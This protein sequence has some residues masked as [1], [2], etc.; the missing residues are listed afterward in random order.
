MPGLFHGFVFFSRP[1]DGNG[2]FP[3]PEASGR[4]ATST[5]RALRA[6][7]RRLGPG[8]ISG[9]LA[10]QIRTQGDRIGLL[11]QLG[12]RTQVAQAEK[13]TRRSEAFGDGVFAIVIT[14]LV[15]I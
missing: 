5:G 13:D 3:I 1:A 10:D 15:L 2:G 8:A 6:L 7:S 12:L 4:C 9:I 11:S 14:P